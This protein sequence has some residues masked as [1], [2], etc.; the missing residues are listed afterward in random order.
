MPEY[1]DPAVKHLREHCS[2]ESVTLLL[3]VSG[4]LNSTIETIEETDATVE[5][6]LGRAT[7]RATAPA[8]TID[9]LI[10]LDEISS[11]ELE[12]E[13]VRPLDEGNRHSRRRVIR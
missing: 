3:G 10:A 11:I 5:T 1:I 7:L 13:D 12:R 4:E 2:D 6:T 8:T 9:D